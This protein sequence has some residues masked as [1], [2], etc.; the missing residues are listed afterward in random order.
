MIMYV[1]EVAIDWHEVLK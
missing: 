1:L